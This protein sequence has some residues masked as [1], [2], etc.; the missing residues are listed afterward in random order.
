MNH[1][2]ISFPGARISLTAINAVVNEVDFDG[3]AT[4]AVYIDYGTQNNRISFEGDV[5]T[6]MEII[7]AYVESV[8][9]R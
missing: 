6:V 4:G 2:L 8:S 5:E 3:K 7:D 9:V 1:D